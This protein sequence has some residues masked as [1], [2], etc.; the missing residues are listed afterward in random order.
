MNKIAVHLTGA[1]YPAGTL[2]M[3]N[4]GQPHSGGSQFFFCYADTPLP[5]Q[6]TPFGKVTSGLDVL[7]AIAKN[8]EDDANG[9]GDGH[10]K[11]DV[12]ITKVTTNG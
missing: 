10:P 6:Y 7:Q 8:G 2:A 4:T 5:P 9:P 3:A 12:T 11:L 1:T